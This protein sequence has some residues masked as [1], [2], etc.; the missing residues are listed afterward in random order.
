M[1]PSAQSVAVAS[2]LFSLVVGFKVLPTQL[3]TSLVASTAVG[4]GAN[5]VVTRDFIPGRPHEVIGDS[6]RWSYW[7]STFTQSVVFNGVLAWRV[8]AHGRLPWFHQVYADATHD[9]LLPHVIFMA[10]LLKDMFWGCLSYLVILH[11]G[12]RLPRGPLHTSAPRSARPPPRPSPPPLPSCAVVCYVC[13]AGAASGGMV[14]GHNIFLT[15]GFSMEVGSLISGLCHLWP[16]SP[17]LVNLLVPL[18]TASNLAGI[19]AAAYYAYADRS[20]ELPS[21][22]ARWGFL[23]VVPILAYLRQVIAHS[24]R[25]DY[26][27]AIAKHGA[28]RAAGSRK[29]PRLAR[30]ES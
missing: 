14:Y 29:S 26:L 20:P 19:A 2:A 5:F 13:A 25:R 6:P 22:I 24:D 9:D 17:L 10:Y 12:A 15:G 30:K 1:A 16:R 8:A 23:V 21:V 18:M 7:I 11:H 4:L 27:A 3:A 28:S